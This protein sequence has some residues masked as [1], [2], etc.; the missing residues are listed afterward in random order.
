MS[1]RERNGS[2]GYASAG[3]NENPSAAIALIHIFPLSLRLRPILS[4]ARARTAD[5]ETY[6]PG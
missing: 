4:R 5:G 6:S 1:K 3:E 2:D